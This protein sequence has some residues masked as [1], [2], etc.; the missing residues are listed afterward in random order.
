VSNAQGEATLVALEPSAGYVVSTEMV[1]FKTVR[2]EGILVR[3]GQT[4]TLRVGLELSDIQEE[5]TVTAESPV[6][7]TTSAT[8]GQ[9][10]TL[11]LTESLPTGRSY[12]S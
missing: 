2:N 3:S 8:T 9:D 12:Q 4:T 6:V 10:I 1:G 7:D 5:V 11:E